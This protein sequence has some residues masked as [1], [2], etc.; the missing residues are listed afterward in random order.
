MYKIAGAVFAG[1]VA[2]FILPAF[3]GLATC[4]LCGVFFAGLLIALFASLIVAR[5]ITVTA[6]KTGSA[7]LNELTIGRPNDS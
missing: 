1:F 3:I 7:F 4:F 5:A 6:V 2:G